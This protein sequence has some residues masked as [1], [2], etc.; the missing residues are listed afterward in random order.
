[1]TIYSTYVEQQGNKKVDTYNDRYQVPSNKEQLRPTIR[2]KISQLKY[3]FLAILVVISKTNPATP[4]SLHTLRY[5]VCTHE[6]R[7]ASYSQSLHPT[8]RPRKPGKNMYFAQN[9]F[10]IFN[11]C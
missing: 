1:M 9:G 3:K 5:N 8:I 10:N 11:K 4:V 6:E 7:C 2:S